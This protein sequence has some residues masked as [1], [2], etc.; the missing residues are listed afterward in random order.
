LTSQDYEY[1]GL[2]ASTWDLLRGDTSHWPD[3]FFFRDLIDRSGQPVLDVGCGTGRLLLDFMA[4]GLD[5]DG[6][7]NSPDMLSICR[8]KA[9]KLGLQ[10]NLYE[11]KMASLALPRKYQTIIVPSSSFQLITDKEDAK[12]AMTRFYGHLEPGGTLAMSFFVIL[13]SDGEV[14][15]RD[16]KLLA[17]ATRPEDGAVVRKW[18]SFRYEVKEQ[19]Q[20]TQDRYEVSLDGEV[21]ASEQHSRSPAV[22]FYRQDQIRELYKAA[23]FTNIHILKDEDSD[24]QPA[25]A[26]DPPAM[27]LG[28][29][30]S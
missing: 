26:E 28:K 17:E 3:R 21:I 6:I 30:P 7:D 27:V 16:W 1:R 15:E 24:W 22:R 19:L 13:W 5:V 11:Q 8:E 2:L 14:L 20:H 9:Q 23:G 25:T 29:R 10:P 18:S 4:D 12:Q